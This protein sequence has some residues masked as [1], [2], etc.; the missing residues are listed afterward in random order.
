M[1]PMIETVALASGSGEPELVH[2]S[3]RVAGIDCPT[4]WFAVTVRLM[5]AIHSGATSP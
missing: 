2:L 3:Y 1:V 4:F 5:I